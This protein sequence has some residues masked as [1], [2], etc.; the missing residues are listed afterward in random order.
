[1]HTKFHYLEVKKDGY[2][3]FESKNSIAAKENKIL[4]KKAIPI[5]ASLWSSAV[6]ARPP[7]S[8]TNSVAINIIFISSPRNL[9][10]QRGYPLHFK[11]I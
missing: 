9:T 6:Y 4:P 5:A 1:M 8:E 7:A 3:A 2:F 10:I 11:I